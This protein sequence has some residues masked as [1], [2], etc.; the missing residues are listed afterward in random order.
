MSCDEVMDLIVFGLGEYE[1]WEGSEFYLVL[2]A[3]IG[4]IHLPIIYGKIMFL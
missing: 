3:W 1:G 4:W 2:C